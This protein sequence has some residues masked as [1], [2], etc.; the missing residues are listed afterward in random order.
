MNKRD[1]FEKIYNN[2][3]QETDV[4]LVNIK[5]FNE[6]YKRYIL[7]NGF[8]FWYYEGDGYVSLAFFKNDDD[9]DYHEEYEIISFE[10]FENAIKERDRLNRIKELEKE[11]NKLKGE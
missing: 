9:I 2:E 4:I 11:L 8:A 10:E 1:L 3:I 5:D 7:N 6:E